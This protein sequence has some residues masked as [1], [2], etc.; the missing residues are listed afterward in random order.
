MTEGGHKNH[1]KPYI[2]T[3]FLRKLRKK[4]RSNVKTEL[5]VFYCLHI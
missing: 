4:E 3:D 1:I 5:I 2:L